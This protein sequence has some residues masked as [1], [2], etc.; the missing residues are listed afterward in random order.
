[1]SF[2]QRFFNAAP[3]EGSPGDHASSFA[4]L[5]DDALEAHLGV[6]RYGDF[7][8]TDAVRPSYDLQVVPSEG[9]RHDVYRD[10]ES[11]TNVPVIMASVSTERL[12]DV[13]LE[14]LE[15]MGFEVDVVLETSHHRESRQ[16]GPGA[17]GEC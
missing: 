6:V 13:F 2:L 5:D 3:R 14:L 15:P 7:R 1:M 12:F 17:W 8:L 4:R 9:Y 10:D 16:H 11:K